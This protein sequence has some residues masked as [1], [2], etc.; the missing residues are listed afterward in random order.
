MDAVQI[1]VSGAMLVVL[2]ILIL[3]PLVW[4]TRNNRILR[5]AV[6]SKINEIS[7]NERKE[8][9]MELVTQPLSRKGSA[10]Y[11]MMLGVVLVI[12]VSVFYLL[13]TDGTSEIAKN[14]LGV[15]AGALASIVGFYFGGRAE[16]V[17]SE[18]LAEAV[19]KVVKS[20]ETPSG[21]PEMKPGG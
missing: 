7:E 3:L 21:G 11:S 4:E 17:K 2:G 16:E 14:T 8:V 10:R 20:R 6:F 5:E 1:I 9:M 15:L 19:E 12:G 13:L 18:E